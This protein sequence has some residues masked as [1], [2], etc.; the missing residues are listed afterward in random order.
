MITLAL[1]GAGGKMGCRIADNIRDAA[2]Y[3]ILYVEP[4]ERGV[5][6]LAERHLGDRR[7]APRRLPRRT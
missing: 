1:F 7:Q 4:G 5:A 3:R 2:A 6:R